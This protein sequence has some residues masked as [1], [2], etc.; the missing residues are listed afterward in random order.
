MLSSFFKPVGDAGIPKYNLNLERDERKVNGI[1][2]HIFP[3][4]DLEEEQVIEVVLVK[5][6]ALIVDIRNNPVLFSR[7]IFPDG[8]GI[9]V[10]VFSIPNFMTIFMV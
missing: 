8:G 7:T 2:A 1:F 9:D 6:V 3:S 4:F 10:E 5:Q